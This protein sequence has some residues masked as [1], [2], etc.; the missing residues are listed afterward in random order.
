MDERPGGNSH[1]E[2]AGDQQELQEQESAQRR[3]PA[4]LEAIGEQL[5]Q[6]EHDDEDG[7]RQQLADA[8]LFTADDA[9]GQ[10]DQIPGDV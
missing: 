6:H 4:R 10:E 9:S 3:E 1:C 8:R 7:N 2:K 5:R